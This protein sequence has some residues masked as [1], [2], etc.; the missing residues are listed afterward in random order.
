MVGNS[1]VSGKVGI[2]G[3]TTFPTNLIYANYRLFVKGG[4]LTDEVRVK[5]STSST[6]A[7]YVFAEGY[8]LKSLKELEDFITK[9]NHLPNVPS[10]NQVKEEGINVADMARI[11]Q[12]KIEELT[13]YII[14]QNKRIEA[15]ET[16][17]NN[18]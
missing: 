6:W 10:G 7:D 11:Q 2:G 3:I 14:Q 13:L 12:E 9:N 17:I 4:I 16:K 1:K 8:K 18:L 15:L 5:L